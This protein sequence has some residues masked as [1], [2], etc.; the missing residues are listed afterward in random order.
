MKNKYYSFQEAQ[1]NLN[2]DRRSGSLIKTFF[3]TN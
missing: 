2:P 3:I 1:Y